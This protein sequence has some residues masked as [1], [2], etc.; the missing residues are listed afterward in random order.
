MTDLACYR[1]TQ[2]APPDERLTA[3]APLVRRIAYYVMA[4]LPPSVQVDDLIQAGMIGLLEASRSYD[5]SQGATFE[6]YAGIRIRGAMIDEIRKY[7]WTPRTLRKKVR[8]VSE[9]I[10]QIESE[11]GRA[12]R[13]SEVARRLGIS[14]EEYHGILRDTAGH[15]L[16][17]LQCMLPSARSSAERAL[18]NGDDPLEQLENERLTQ[19]LSAAIGGLPEK[20]RLVMAMYY[21]EELNMREIGALMGVS[22][23]RICQIHSQALLRIRARLR[24]WAKGESGDREGGSSRAS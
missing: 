12:A 9:A 6:T 13:D 19:A 18:V 22:E 16:V 4:R 5:P 10:A 20:E 23:A 14:L 21:D 2:A 11:Q 7:D 17:S 1:E 15:K 3:C 8:E 24:W